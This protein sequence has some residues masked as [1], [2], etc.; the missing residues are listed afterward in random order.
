MSDKPQYQLSY[1]CSLC[2]RRWIALDDVKGNQMC[3]CGYLTSPH[4]VS[5][6]NLSQVRYWEFWDQVE[7][8]RDGSGS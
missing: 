6:Y 7:A 2:G 8:Y 3:A 1:K 4:T 5:S